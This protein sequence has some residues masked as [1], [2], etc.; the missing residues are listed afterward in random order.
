MGMSHRSSNR[1]L[2]GVKTEIELVHSS[3]LPTSCEYPNF[4]IASR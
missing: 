2:K 4:A 3:P 1:R